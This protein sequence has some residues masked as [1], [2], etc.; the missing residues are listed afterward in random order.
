MFSKKLFKVLWWLEQWEI[1]LFYRSLLTNPK[2]FFKGIFINTDV[3]YFDQLSG[4]TCA[5]KLV[6]TLFFQLK[7]VKNQI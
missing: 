2:D 6:E 5:R 3:V 1:S 4:A 7:K